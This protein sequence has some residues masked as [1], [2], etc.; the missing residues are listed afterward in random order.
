[1]RLGT[2]SG[3]IRFNGVPGQAMEQVKGEGRPG[4]WG[5]AGLA[6]GRNRESGAVPRSRGEGVRPRPGV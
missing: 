1:M 6:A 4:P 2:R 3:R 5:S